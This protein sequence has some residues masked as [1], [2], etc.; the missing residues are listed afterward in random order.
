MPCAAI[1]ACNTCGQERAAGEFQGHRSGMM[2]DMQSKPGH[3][4]ICKK[5]GKQPHTFVEYIWANTRPEKW[6]L[7]VGRA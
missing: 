2:A 7:L 4:L 3:W 6:K 5:C 1:F